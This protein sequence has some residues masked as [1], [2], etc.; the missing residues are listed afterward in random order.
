MIVILDS[1]KN[2]PDV[3]SL[4]VLRAVLSASNTNRFCIHYIVTDDTLKLFCPL[5]PGGSSTQIKLQAEVSQKTK[6][7]IQGI[8]LQEKHKRER[9][10][11]NVH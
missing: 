7:F 11:K 2:W 8:R 10:Y 6:R 5:K 9:L 4:T 3:Y 1:L